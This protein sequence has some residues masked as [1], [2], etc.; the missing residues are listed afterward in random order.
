[1]FFVSKKKKIK[2]YLQSKAETAKTAFDLLL[3]DYLSG[4]LKAELARFGLAGL[5]IC[6]DWFEDTKCIGVQGKYGAYYMDLQIGAESFELSFC[7]DEPEEE[8][9]SLPLESKEQMYSV[10][11]EAMQTLK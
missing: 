3:Q 8:G 5:E 7:A 11:K 9:E 1:M 10:I 4:A 2:A 6:V